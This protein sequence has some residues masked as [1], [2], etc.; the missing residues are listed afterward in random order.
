LPFLVD[1]AFDEHNPYPA[2]P[3][4]I[5]AKKEKRKE[6]SSHSN[7][8][9]KFV[10]ILCLEIAWSVAKPRCPAQSYLLNAAHFYILYGLFK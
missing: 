2:P 6:L 10:V 5:Q 4:D 7:S 8:F 3:N 1:A 9:T